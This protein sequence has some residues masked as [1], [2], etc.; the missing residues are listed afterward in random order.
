MEDKAQAE[1]R[2]KARRIAQAEDKQSDT[3]LDSL[4]TPNTDASQNQ[5]SRRKKELASNDTLPV[6][7]TT[8]L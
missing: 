1:G 5:S 6:S 7:A 2:E 8:A 4:K 3:Y